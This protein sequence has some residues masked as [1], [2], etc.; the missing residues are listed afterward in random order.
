LLD[1]GSLSAIGQA[2]VTSALKD[3][4]GKLTGP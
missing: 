4:P 1:G 2:T 3:L